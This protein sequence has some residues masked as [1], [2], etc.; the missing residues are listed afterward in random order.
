MDVFLGSTATAA[1]YIQQTV[2]RHLTQVTGREGGQLVVFTHFVGQ[3]GI[4]VKR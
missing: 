3:S 4:G 1:G 2:L